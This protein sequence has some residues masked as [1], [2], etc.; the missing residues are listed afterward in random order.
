MKEKIYSIVLKGEAPYSERIRDNFCSMCK[1]RRYIT[2][3]HDHPPCFVS[4]NGVCVRFEYI[5]D[6][7]RK[8]YEQE[9]LEGQAFTLWLK[10]GKSPEE[11]YAMSKEEFLS[12]LTKKYYAQFEK[13]EQEDRRDLA[14]MV[15]RSNQAVEE[16][17]VVKKRGRKK[18]TGRTGT[19][20]MKEIK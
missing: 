7:V 10:K 1:Y 20:G 12:I 13:R 5:S 9:V 14:R 4:C 16:A 6:K 18:K 8:R 2:D 15:E 11:V 3:T 19:P 17:L